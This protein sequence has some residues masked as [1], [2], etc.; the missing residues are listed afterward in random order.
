MNHYLI[1]LKR[2]ADY[3]QDEIIVMDSARTPVPLLDAE[4][5][6]HPSDGT[7]DVVWNEGNSKL[8]M[9]STGVIRFIVDLEEIAAYSWSMGS[10]CLAI[11]YSNGKRDRSF[12]TGPIQ[13]EDKCLPTS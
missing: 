8:V 3:W 7:A 10:Y 2:D 11:T 6:I 1:T 5:T 9:P 13:I 4:L 12:L